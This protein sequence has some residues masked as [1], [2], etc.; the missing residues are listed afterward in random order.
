MGSFEI[1]ASDP[2]CWARAGVL[3]TAHGPVK[4]PTFM[5]VGTSGAIKGILPAQLRSLGVEMI[6]ANTYH[7]LVR[8]GVQVVQQIGGLGRFMAWDGPILTDSGGYQVLSLGSLVRIKDDGVEFA[9]HLDGRRIHLDPSSAIEIQNRL[10]ADVIMCLDQCPASSASYQQVQ[11]AVERT[12]LWA[13]Q[14]RQ[15]HRRE[16]QMIFGIVQGGIY[17]QLRTTCAKALLEIGFDGYAIGGLGI[18]EGHERMVEMVRTTNQLLPKDRPRYLMGVGTPADIL[19]AVAAG[20]DMFDCVLPT[21]N[22][23]N[24]YA[25]TAQGPIR[26]RNSAYSADQA[27]IEEGCDCYACKHYCRAAIRHFFNINEMLGPILLSIHNIRFYQKLMAHIRARILDGS[28]SDWAKE[29]SARFKVYLG[30][31]DL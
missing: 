26:I 13:R 25:F 14:C 3:D 4:T 15:A 27:P 21:R 20:V 29:Q 9:N 6:L 8:P 22:G 28:F 12:I 17:P 16:D 10:G 1:L 2:V 11:Q 31:Q 19:A 23:R 5:P 24:G 30:P 18:G 7:L